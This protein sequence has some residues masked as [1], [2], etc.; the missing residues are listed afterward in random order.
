MPATSSTPPCIVF[1]DLD[2]TLFD[3][4]HCTRTALAAVRRTY[5]CFEQWTP[6][7]LEQR[8]SVVLEE[9]HLRVLAA[10]LPLDAA[11][12]ERFRRLFAAAGAEAG[13]AVVEACAAGYKEDYIRAWRP[14]PG[15]LEL[16][17]RLQP[18]TR[19]GIISN[20]LLREQLEKIRYCGIDRYVD[21]TVISEGAGVAKPDPRIF[22]MALAEAGCTAAEAVM[23]GDAWRTDIAGALAAGIRPVWVNWDGVAP[24]SPSPRVA[25]VRGLQPIEPLAELIRRPPPMV[26]GDP[27]PAC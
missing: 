2:D 6:R 14:V 25:E 23:V 18:E 21:V 12:R 22:A 19:L 17:D 9:L 10:D 13:T 11:R 4:R 7:E 3:H 8:H 1:F 26:A 27:A 5:P 20:N 15:A 24:A 16:L